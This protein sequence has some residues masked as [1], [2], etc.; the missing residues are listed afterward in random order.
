M[1]DARDRIQRSIPPRPPS[2]RLI[3]ASLL[4]QVSAPL[5]IFL[6]GAL[7]VQ[8]KGE[9]GIDDRGVGLAVAV[10]FLAASV[11]AAA[12]GRLAD[13]VG[14]NHAAHVALAGCGVTLLGVALFAHSQTSL[15]ALVV[16]GG[17]ATAIG[18]PAANLALA[19]RGLMPRRRALLFVI[20]QLALPLSALMA[21]ASVPAIAL[22]VGWRWAYVFGLLIPAVGAVIVPLRRPAVATT[23]RNAQGNMRVVSGPLLSMAGAACLGIVGT[24]VLSAFL[25]VSSVDA[26]LS[27]AMA[28]TLVAVA[29]AVAFVVMLGAAVVVDRAP[30]RVFRAVA[31]LQVCASCGFLL[32]SSQSFPPYAFGAVLA[33]A[34]GW[35]WTGLFQYSVVLS[36]PH[37]PGSASGV[38]ETGLAVGASAGPLI[39]GAVAFDAGFPAAWI[40]VAA[41]MTA[42]ASL[43]I[44]TDRRV[45]MDLSKPV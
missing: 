3:L 20:K 21:G 39:F 34:A 23:R 37:A 16:F 29:N 43:I 31:L 24:S 12:S 35:G 19:Q 38:T 7:A 26:G 17:A 11:V 4:T 18:F 40:G 42:A 9:L 2:A 27:P 44:F 14:W 10:Y 36:H 15:L 8:I 28:G 45:K 5:P 41:V 25:V 32:L 22:R 30:A 13:R 33:Y 1:H 6:L